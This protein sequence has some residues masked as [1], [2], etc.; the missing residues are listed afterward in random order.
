MSRYLLKH[1]WVW[2]QFHSSTEMKDKINVLD[3]DMLLTCDQDDLVSKGLSC[4]S[5][6]M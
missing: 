3:L 6:L 4:L 2:V 5:I 1:T